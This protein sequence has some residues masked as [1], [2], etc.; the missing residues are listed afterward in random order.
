M[1]IQAGW[2]PRRRNGRALAGP[3][4]TRRPHHA[5]QPSS[6][7]FAERFVGTVRG[8]CT[9]RMLI[10]GERHLRAVV[11]EHVT[12]YNT[13]RSH[14]RHDMRLRAPDDPDIIPFPAQPDRIRRNRVLGGLINQYKPA[15]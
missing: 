4:H 15:A 9:D 11:A 10:T 13:G 2:L 1:N 5:P 14:Q 7:L 3:R 8:E 12:H 6:E